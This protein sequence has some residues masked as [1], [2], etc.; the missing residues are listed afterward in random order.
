LW[1]G[2]KGNLPNIKFIIGGAIGIL[3]F[4][5]LAPLGLTAMED[6]V[7]TDP[8]MVIVW[9]LVAVFFVIGVGLS[10]I[11]EAMGD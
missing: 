1:G 10:Y 9:P 8:T 6:Y 4:G 11:W 2:E 7:P 5:L 3:L